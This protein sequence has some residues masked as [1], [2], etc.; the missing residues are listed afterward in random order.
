MLLQR[1]FVPPEDKYDCL[2]LFA[3]KCAISK[4]YKR[5]GYTYAVLDFAL[6]RRDEPCS[7]KEIV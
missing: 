3:G 7:K 6:D 5:K 1:A 2:D 4:A